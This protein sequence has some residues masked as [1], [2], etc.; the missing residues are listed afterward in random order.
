[1]PSTPFS[2]VHHL[3]TVP[4]VVDGSVE[5][6][7]VL[8]TGIGLNLCS[9]S[10]CEAIGC[11]PNGSTFTGRRMSGQE[12]AIPLGSGVELA[13][14]SFTRTDL[15][16]GIFDMSGFTADFDG[17][18]GFL[19]L[20]FFE[21]APF[22]VDYRRQVVIVESAESL[23]LRAGEGQTVRV[24]LERDGPSVV[25]FLPLTI[26]GGR[27]ISVE[28]D[29]GSDSL[30]LDAALAAG[31][32]VNLDD[33]GMRRVEGKDET[34]QAYARSFTQ[35]EGAIHIANAPSIR[36]ADPEVMFQEIIYDGLVGDAFLRRFVVTYDL[37]G[38]R[39]IFAPATAPA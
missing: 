37:E 35:L 14:G 20:G 10:L 12:M 29:M 1:M 8:D 17:I 27:T 13:M 19:S 25:A 15:E 18:G 9:E 5:T 36:Q 16:V 31:V 6:R 22:T 4:V 30:I 3:V 7:F 26:P 28:V 11:S 2:Y 39:M 24:R 23:A 33:E 32:G 21:E 34:G 38:S